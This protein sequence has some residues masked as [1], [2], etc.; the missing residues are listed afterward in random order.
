MSL[1]CGVERLRP[2]G[3]SPSTRGSDPDPLLII[4]PVPRSTAGEVP[5]GKLRN[6]VSSIWCICGILELN[7]LG[8]MKSQ[9]HSFRKP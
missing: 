3:K 4:Q 6:M 9:F 1:A 2:R 7:F 8:I 5:A